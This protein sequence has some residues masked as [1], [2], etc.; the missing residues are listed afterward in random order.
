MR[1]LGLLLLLLLVA[2]GCGRIQS[3]RFAQES[4]EQDA[5]FEMELTLNGDAAV[6]QPG[7]LT[8]SLTTVDGEALEGAT[9]QVEG[10][11]THAGMEPLLTVAE[12]SAAGEYQALLDWTMG[13]EW[14]V[15]VR[16]SLPDGTSVERTLTGVE[17]A[18]P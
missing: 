2:A 6:G 12:P 18:S 15:R 13:G 5:P 9:V 1:V 17:V 14:F 4:G 3:G 8:V 10:N 11:M 16:A 7:M